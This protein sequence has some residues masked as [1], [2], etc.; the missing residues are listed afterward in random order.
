MEEDFKVLEPNTYLIDSVQSNLYKFDIDEDFETPSQVRD[1]IRL[2][3]TQEESDTTILRVN[4]YGGHAFTMISVM[5]AIRNSKGKVIAQVIHA[6]SAGSLLSLACDDCYTVPY[7]E[8]YIHEMQSGHYGD[9]SYQAKQ[10]K[11]LKKSQRRLFEEVYKGFLTDKEIDD[12]CEGRIRDYSFD[13]VEANERLVKWREYKQR[14]ITEK[15][16][17]SENE[18]EGE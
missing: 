13:E 11:F 6:S 10:V 16:D 8:W 17:I 12:L 18:K 14:L 2:L 3:D 9:T 7:G 4:I 1:L 15:E 5:D